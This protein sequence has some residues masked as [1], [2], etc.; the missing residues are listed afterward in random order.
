MH[1]YFTN[2]LRIIRNKL[3]KNNRNQNYILINYFRLRVKELRFV[4]F[5][6]LCPRLEAPSEANKLYL[7]VICFSLISE[8]DTCIF[9]K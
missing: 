1:T 2:E 4:H 9:F 6:I 8:N 7:F 5:E 3:L